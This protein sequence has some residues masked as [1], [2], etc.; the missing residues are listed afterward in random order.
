MLRAANCRH[1]SSSSRSRER[2]GWSKL[3]AVDGHHKLAAHHSG[4]LIDSLPMQTIMQARAGTATVDRDRMAAAIVRLR[5]AEVVS[6]GVLFYTVAAAGQRTMG[7]LRISSAIWVAAPLAGLVTATLGSCAAGHGALGAGNSVSM[8]LTGKFAHSDPA[9][10]LQSTCAFAAVGLFSFWIL[11]GRSVMLCPSDLRHL[12]AYARLGI[13]CT[14]DY[15]DS[16]MRGRVQVCKL[17]HV[18][19]CRGHSIDVFDDSPH[20]NQ[21]V[22]WTDDRTHFW[23]S[24]MRHPPSTR[25]TVV[26]C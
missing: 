18:E 7:A 21:A 17:L 15:A 22:S 12:G 9:N 11:G 8:A 6:G 25:T 24:F 16:A 14:V 3:C 10:H 2:P 1:S 20:S 4:W 19:F 26:G 13:P 23:V 5:V